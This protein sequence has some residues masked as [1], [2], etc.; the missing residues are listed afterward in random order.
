MYVPLARSDYYGSSA[1]PTADSRQRACPPPNGMSGG[2]ATV[3]GSHVHQ[4]P[5]GQL[6][7]QLYPDSLATPTPQAFTVASPPT[8][9]SGFGVDLPEKPGQLVRCDTAHIHQVGA[10]TTLT[11]LRPLVHSRYT[12]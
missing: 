2:R 1:P 3:D 9:L 11:G 4:Q 10:V 5:I 6:G 8:S 7:A 12:F